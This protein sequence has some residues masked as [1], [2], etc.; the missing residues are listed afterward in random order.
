MFNIL[1]YEKLEKEGKTPGELYLI[2]HFEGLNDLRCLKILCTIYK[3]P[4]SEAK[5][6]IIK[7]QTGCNSLDEYQE[8]HVLPMLT[9][10]L[11]TE[12]RDVN[13]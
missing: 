1:K 12:K 5:E 10:Y 9:N 8:K 4:L 2:M 6:V 7:H 11:E 13:K 3:M